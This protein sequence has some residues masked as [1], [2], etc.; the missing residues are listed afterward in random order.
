MSA[1]W[2]PR[3]PADLAPWGA[4]PD[5]AVTPM[6]VDDVPGVIA[7]ERCIYVFPWTEGNFV[8]SLR[9]GY[10]GWVFSRGHDLVGYAM[11][12]WSLD[13]V[14]LLNLSV[15]GH[16]Q[17]QGVG[18]AMLR[19]LLGQVG[20]RGASSMLLEVRPSNPVAQHLYETLGFE[21]IGLRKGY[22][23][24]MHSKREDAIVM[25]RSIELQADDPIDGA[26]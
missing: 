11:L 9:A 15:A 12:A 4:S 26:V 23:P 25:R 19:W 10:D 2:Q 20:R 24:S 5:L 1:Q 8:D 18:A 7:I 6:H 16:A 14:H 17:R 13:E 3:A 21:A 22:Y